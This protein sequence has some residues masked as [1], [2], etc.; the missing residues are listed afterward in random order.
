MRYIIMKSEDLFE[1]P[2]EVQDKYDN[3]TP[4]HKVVQCPIN[5]Y[6]EFC[7]KHHYY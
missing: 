5:L 3:G 1:V 4:T 6:F 2:R 7:M